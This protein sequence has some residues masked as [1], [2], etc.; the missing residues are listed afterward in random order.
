M[1]AT[2]LRAMQWTT[3]SNVLRSA[4]QLIQLVVLT[5]LLSPQDYGLMAL[6]LMVIGFAALF[7][8]I[9]L[10]TAFV[11]RQ[12]ISEPE[13]SSLYWLSVAVGVV[14]MLIVAISSPLI[15]ILLNEPRL[16]PLLILVSTNFLVVALGQQLRM[17]SEKSLSFKPIAL[18]EIASSISGFIVAVIAA[19]MSLGVYALVVAAMVSTWLTMLLNWVVLAKGWRPMLHFCWRD[20]RWFMHFGG[21]MVIVNVI[22]HVNSNIDLILGGRLL[23]A[24]QLG[25]YSVP[26]NLILQIQ[27]MV[28]P[29]FTRV[30]FPVMASIQND[31]RLVKDIYL[32]IMRLTATVNAPIYVAIALF[33][34]EIVH[35]MLGEQFHDA[36]PLLR[37][38]ALW[39]LLRSFANPIGAMLFALGR[40][41]LSVWWNAGLMFCIPPALWLGSHYGS[42]GMAWAMTIM[43]AILFVPA[44]ALL[45]RPTCGAGFYIYAKQVIVPS[46]FAVTAGAL[47]W[48]AA[49]AFVLPSVRL[50]VG[51]SVGAISYIS[52]IWFI[53]RD[54]RAMVIESLRNS[55]KI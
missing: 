25:I 34:S 4:L 54:I 50:I 27:F 23:G 53:D 52:L 5:R 14:L 49:H 20:V 13:R 31:K 37:V 46:L 44:W 33:A 6:V 41:R 1:H 21:G 55:A 9:G 17:N 15:A 2:A 30:G 51:L 39:G 45:V 10:S 18:I 29:I 47:A 26:R 42:I 32:K 19:W 8:D 16:I 40:V 3:V 35:M 24:S 7:S 22:N 48:L 38:F 28:N 36:V 12:N 43:M 11:Q